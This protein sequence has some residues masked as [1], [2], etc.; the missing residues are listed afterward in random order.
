[1]AYGAS[2]FAQWMSARSADKKFGLHAEA[3]EGGRKDAEVGVTMYPQDM[4]L[5]LRRLGDKAD[6]DP[7]TIQTKWRPKLAE[8][9]PHKAATQK[10]IKAF[11]SAGEAADLMGF[12]GLN[13]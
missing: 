1:M 3:K 9:A 13:G 12:G 8:A 2:E 7:A 11:N 5:G 4:L 6:D 10:L